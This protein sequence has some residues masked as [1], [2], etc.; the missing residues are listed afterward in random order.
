MLRAGESRTFSFE[1]SPMRDLSFVDDDGRRFLENGEF[2]VIVNGKKARFV[3][4]DGPSPFEPL[5]H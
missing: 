4:S 3:V 5:S 1:I 2:F